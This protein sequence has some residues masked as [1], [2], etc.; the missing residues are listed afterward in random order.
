VFGGR[1]RAGVLNALESLSLGTIALGIA[2]ISSIV[3]WLLTHIEVKAVT[4]IFGLGTPLGLAYCIYWLPVWMGRDP[5]EYASWA[6]LF[7][8]PWFVAGAV[9]AAGTIVISQMRRRAAR[10]ATSGPTRVADRPE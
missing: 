7:I 5:S 9:P 3:A 2:V 8:T 10:S 4:W 1:R 6:P